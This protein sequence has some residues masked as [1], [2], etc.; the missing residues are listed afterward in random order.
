MPISAAFAYGVD[1]HLGGVLD[2]NCGFS[3]PGQTGCSE[4]LTPLDLM[5]R[6]CAEERFVVT[7]SNGRRLTNAWVAGGR[8]VRLD[9]YPRHSLDF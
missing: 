7:F 5:T 6:D 3:R 9:D 2:V 4:S 8:I 1:D